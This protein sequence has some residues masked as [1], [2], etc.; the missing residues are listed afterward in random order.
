MIDML[1]QVELGNYFAIWKIILFLV[2][3]GGWAW[4]GQWLDKDAPKVRTNRSFWNNI[5]LGTVAGAL[6]MFFV[7]PAPFIVELLLFLVVWLTVSVIYVLHRNARVEPQNRILTPDHIKSLFT[8]E[9]RQSHTERRLVFIS[10][11]KNELPLPNRQDPEF[12]GYGGA[13]DLIYD[14]TFRR[15]SRAEMVPAGENAQIKV[16]IDGLVTASERPRIEVEPALNYLKAVASLD[17]KERRRPQAG[18]FH[19]RIDKNKVL[20]RIHTAGSTRGEQMLLE[21]VEE[22]ARLN[23]ENLGLNPD[24]LSGMQ[25]MIKQKS[26]LALIC[27]GR[28]TGLTTTLYAVL[29]QHDAFMTNINT[30]EKDPMLDLDNITQNIIDKTPGVDPVKQLQSVLR[31][32]PDILMVS[33]CDNAEMAKQGT[34]AARDGKK[35]YFGLPYGSTFQVLEEW[36]KMLQRPDKVAD[37]LQAITTQKLLRKLCLECREAYIPDGNLLKKLNLPADKIKQFYRPPKELQ[38]DRHGKPLLCPNCQGTG[39]YGRSAIF[40]TLFL[41]DTV[42]KLIRDQAPLNV[43]RGQCRKERLLFLQEQALRKVI[44]GT[45]SI[46]EVLRVTGDGGAGAGPARPKPPSGTGAGQPAPQA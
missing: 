39:Y 38:Y 40:E 46:Q 23:L 44:D 7:L 10:A 9:N 32:D 11:N 34:E 29:R 5:Y 12:D 24:Q 3:F 2:L 41:S 33:F 14:L 16:V 19:V 35:I 42:K 36:L 30:L 17:T 4:V 37:T 15:V 27:G 28:G 21:R 20:W 8:H 6:V 43:I 45:T 26:G 31:K 25:E 18:E 22:F 1:G 13:E